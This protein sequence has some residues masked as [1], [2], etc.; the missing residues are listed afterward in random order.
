[1]RTHHKGNI[2]TG[3]ISIV[4]ALRSDMNV[5]SLFIQDTVADLYLNLVM[6]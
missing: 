1:M 6:N 5:T 3:D 2:N 4:E